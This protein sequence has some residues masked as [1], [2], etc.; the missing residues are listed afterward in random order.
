MDEYFVKNVY[1]GDGERLPLLVSKS[2]L[3]GVFDVAAFA[4][5]LREQSN[6]LKTIVSAIRAV[7][8][9]YEVLHEKKVCLNQRASQNKLLTQAEINAVSTRCKVRKD[10]L[11][12]PRKRVISLAAAH[13][14][15]GRFTR[16]KDEAVSPKTAVL[17]LHYIITFLEEF[18]RRACLSSTPSNPDEFRQLSEL[19][20]KALKAKKPVV[21]K[22]SDRRGIPE[23]AE[24]HLYEVTDVHYAHNPWRTDFLRHRN[25][26]IVKLLIGLG[27]RKGELLGIK[28]SDVN[29]R[30]GLLFIAKRP[31]DKD[32]RRGRPA[33]TKTLPRLLALNDELVQLLL[34][35]TEQV[36]PTRRLAEYNPYLIVSDEGNEFSSS[37]MDYVFS[38]L[39]KA[40]PE[41]VKISAH[42]LRHTV[43]DRFAE[44]CEGMDASLVRL[45]QNY[46]MGW[47]KGSETSETYTKA[48]VE[49]KAGEVYLS[50][51]GKMFK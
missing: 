34:Y 3:L 49:K 36:R 5:A 1:F 46:L 13:R 47:S 51:Q 31:N 44:L 40:F 8:L 33:T 39:R 30:N 16:G 32:D 37:S 42:V 20:I 10:A 6:T 50:L 29:L 18:T 11:D 25:Q 48:Y 12:D 15:K 26:L 9:L 28:M 7:K 23:E 24:R 19:S 14:K 43:N 41:F 27:V 4:L 22:G 45:I 17:Q 21:P 2:T 38:S 35:Y